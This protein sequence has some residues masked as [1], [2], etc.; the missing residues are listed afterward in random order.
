MVQWHA[1]FKSL[2]VK[3]AN[4]SV[5]A[6][7]DRHLHDSNLNKQHNKTANELDL[8]DLVCYCLRMKQFRSHL[9]I[10]L[11][12]NSIIML[13]NSHAPCLLLILEWVLFLSSSQFPIF[14]LFWFLSHP[15]SIART[16]AVMEVASWDKR[17]HVFHEDSLQLLVVEYRTELGFDVCIINNQCDAI[18]TKSY[19]N[20]IL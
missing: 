3:W 8:N 16:S 10:T 18:V 15:C 11:H 2:T 12:K 17:F 14:V 4:I 13:H 9:E 5:V 20:D 6:C 19:L 7:A 1:T